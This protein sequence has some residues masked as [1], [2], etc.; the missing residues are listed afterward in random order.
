MAN[1]LIPRLTLEPDGVTFVA[2]R[3]PAEAAAQAEFVASVDTWFRP[4][5]Y[6]NAP[7]G[8]RH[9][10]DMVRE[11]I[12]HPWS[13]PDDIK[14]PLDLRGGAD[15]GRIDRLA[16]PGFRP[17]APARLGQASTAALVALL[18]H[19]NGWH[20]DT[21][22]RLIVERQDPAAIAPLRRSLRESRVPL[23]RLHALWSLQ[24]LEALTDDDLQA[25]LADAAA[26][27]R[28]HA[29]LLAE[30]RL[31]RAPRLCDRVLGRAGD[32][33]ARV[34]FQVAFTL[35]EV[36]DPRG[37]GAGPDRPPRR[38]RPLGPHGRPELGHA[39]G[40]GPAGDPAG[41]WELRPA[42]RFRPPAPRPGVPGWRAGPGR[43][44]RPD[45]GGDGP[46]PSGLGS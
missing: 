42:P 37:G 23:G 1:N 34:R 3:A 2:R 10:L 6:I 38:R 17:P 25:A 39:R 29:V 22:H 16:P 12:E 31:D 5:N 30:P 46:Q 4:V 36:A 15:R 19:P 9:V 14:M 45:P 20:R 44:G 18:E 27:V 8:T 26:G 41:R 35:G 43:R 13:I 40:G 32:P 33:A 21:A 7:D 11:T 28:E 24:G